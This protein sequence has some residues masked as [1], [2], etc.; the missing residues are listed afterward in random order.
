MEFRKNPI[1]LARVKIARRVLETIIGVHGAFLTR[2][3]LSPRWVMVKRDNEF[4]KKKKRKKK[5]PITRL[6][7]LEIFRS[8]DG[9]IKIKRGGEGMRGVERLIRFL[10]R[11]FQAT[12]R[13]RTFFRFDPCTK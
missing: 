13:E 3:S 10:F 4:G 6:S 2:A 11:F 9:G 1:S 8:I 7:G 5:P 12:P